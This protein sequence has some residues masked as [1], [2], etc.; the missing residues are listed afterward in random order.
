MDRQQALETLGIYEGTSK[1]RIEEKFSGLMNGAT[2]QQVILLQEARA[3]L[4]EDAP[5][6][7]MSSAVVVNPSDA[8]RK[9]GPTIIIAL[10][11]G[12]LLCVGF[13]V[14]GIYMFDR[15]ANPKEANSRLVEAEQLALDYNSFVESSGATPNAKAE[16]AATHLEEGKKL[17]NAKEYSRASEKLMSARN[18]YVEAFNEEA[19]LT[20]EIWNLQVVEAFNLKLKAN[21]PFNTESKTEAEVADVVA[22][23]NPVDGALRRASQRITT[24]SIVKLDDKPIF[25]PPAN[26]RASVGTGMRISEALFTTG[27]KELIVEFDARLLPVSKRNGLVVAFEDQ[28]VRSDSPDS[29]SCTI[30]L[31]GK[32]KVTFVAMKGFALIPR[33]KRSEFNK[34]PAIKFESVWG[35]GGAL[36]QFSKLAQAD[37]RTVVWESNPLRLAKARENPKDRKD[38]KDRKELLITRLHLTTKTDAN[39]FNPEIYAAFRP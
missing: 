38:S 36:R 24:L 2:E 35:L 19:R 12:I 31:D 28:Q 6:V 30:E 39:A 9:S 25:T 4:L 5:S 14:G 23:F 8:G 27:T 22:I 34:R 26:Y 16:E 1:Q 17:K 21:F 37:G 13:A 10:V 11:L 15:K 32:S 29:I 18:A 7:S 20:S 3:I 33:D